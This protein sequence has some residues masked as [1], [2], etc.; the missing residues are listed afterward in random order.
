MSSMPTVARASTIVVGLSGLLLFAVAD[1]GVCTF[2]PIADART[3]AASNSTVTWV[4]AVTWPGTTK[5]NSSSRLCGFCTMPT[6]RRD[7]PA[8][9]SVLPMLRCRAEATPLVTAT[10]PGPSG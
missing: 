10:W 7:V 4:G 9:R 6:T 2:G 3:P 1:A 8:D 5:A